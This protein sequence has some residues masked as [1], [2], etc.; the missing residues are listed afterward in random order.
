MSNLIIASVKLW[1]WQENSND[2]RQ[3]WAKSRKRRTVVVHGHH[4]YTKSDYSDADGHLAEIRDGPFV[5]S[6]TTTLPVSSVLELNLF[7]M[8]FHIVLHLDFYELLTCDSGRMH[9][10]VTT[11]SSQFFHFISLRL[12]KKKL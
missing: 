4:R 6:Q 11:C 5:K 10:H 3:Q 2:E 12:K 9:W 7:V 1:R 8:C